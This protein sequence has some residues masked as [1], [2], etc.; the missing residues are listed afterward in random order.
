[1]MRLLRYFHT[2]RYLKPVQIL[3]RLTFLAFRPRVD[4]AP[5]PPLR[6]PVAVLPP[7]VPRPSSMLG[8]SRFRFLNQVHD[9]T[10]SADWTAC[11][12]LKL[13][14]YNLHYFDDI[15]AD[16][17]ESRSTWHTSLIARWIAENPPPL[18]DGWEPYPLSLR[19]VNWIKGDL[20]RRGLLDEAARHSLA[21]QVRFLTGRLE[22]HLLGNHLLANAKALVFAGLYF[23]GGEGEAWLRQGLALY[24]RQLPEEIYPDWARNDGHE[25]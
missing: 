19:I 8:P 15:T 9:V 7:G 3:G 22:W 23:A 11:D 5:A 18:G 13:W 12:R 24:A 14:R 16:A 6:D 10:Q 17:A 20:R 1:M 25:E 4:R 21:T 2:L